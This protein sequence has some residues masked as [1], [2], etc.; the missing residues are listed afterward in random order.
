[1]AAPWNRDCRR[2]WSIRD[3]AAGESLRRAPY[4]LSLLI[5]DCPLSPF[6]SRACAAQRRSLLRNQNAAPAKLA[7]LQIVN[8]LVGSLQRIAPGIQRDLALAGQRHQLHQIIIRANQI[9]DKADLAGD[10]V[11]CGH[12]QLSAVAD[13]IVA[14]GALEHANAIHKRISL[15]NEIQNDLGAPTTGNLAHRRYLAALREHRVI[16]A[17]LATQVKRSAGT[18]HDNDLCWRQR[19]EALNADVA[20][21]ARA[22][23]HRSRARVEMRRGLLN[24]VIGSDSGVGQRGNIRGIHARIQLDY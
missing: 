7:A 11:N 17:P 24:G 14:A 3:R 6:H 22:D 8:S 20:Q 13:Q 18:I 9:S 16:G 4:T 1:M 5:E 12:D 21:A 23:D 2:R 19:L 15:A 10:N